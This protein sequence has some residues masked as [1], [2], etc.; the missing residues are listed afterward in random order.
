MGAEPGGV[1]DADPGRAVVGQPDRP[2]DAAA[3]IA[4]GAH[5]GPHPPPAAAHG[6][7]LFAAGAADRGAGAAD[8]AERAADRRVGQAAAGAVPL[9][10]PVRAVLHRGG[11]V[12]H[13]EQPLPDLG[14]AGL[15]RDR[16]HPDDAGILRGAHPARLRAGADGRRE[17][18]PR[19]AVVAR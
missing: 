2:H 13:A 14:S 9:P 15:R 11:R 1:A 18:P 4:D 19:V 6:Q 5:A 8:G 10:V 7:R 3:A 16:R 17:L 12:Q